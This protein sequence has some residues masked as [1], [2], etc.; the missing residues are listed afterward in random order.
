MHKNFSSLYIHIPFC[1]KKCGY[2]DFYSLTLLSLKKEYIKALR[3]EFE[4][5]ASMINENLSPLKTLYI[6]GGTPSVLDCDEIDEVFSII[7]S[8]IDLKG[9]D[10]ITFEINPDSF[11]L[12]KLKVLE[13]Y[14]VKRISIGLQSA[15]DK[16]LSFLGR[17]HN[18][19]DFIKVYSLLEDFNVN[20]DLIYG[21]P[22]QGFNDFKKSVERIVNLNPKPKH[23]SLYPL[24]IHSN[25]SFFGRFDVDENIQREI[26]EKS[27]DLLEKYGYTHYEVSNFSLDGYQSAHNL[28][29]W[30]RGNYLGFGPSAASCLG[31]ERWRNI[32]N[33]YSYIES[34]NNGKIELDYYEKLNEKDVMNERLMLYLRKREGIE[35]GCDV[36]NFFRKEIEQKILQGYLEVID[37][38]VRIKKDYI[39]VSNGIVSSMM[40]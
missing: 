4:L 36:F 8:Y 18:F 31:Y 5:R 24:E 3:K 1:K 38:S 29:Y 40:K 13:R 30:N 12:S 32:T 35:I 28:N 17:I 27:V 11:N 34:L 6:G 15:D 25:T 26:Y 10:E 7:T 33:V 16:E 9:L 14:G 22:A 39:F 21:L 23:I 2:C 37:N 20:V 19:N